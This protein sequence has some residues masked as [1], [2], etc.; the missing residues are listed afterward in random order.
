MYAH[1]MP[2]L[3]YEQEQ[4]LGNRLAQPQ[5]Y[6]DWR[7]ARDTLIL[8]NLGLVGALARKYQNDMYSYED[9]MQE[10][11]IGLIQAV[12][13]FQPCRG[14]RL[15]TYAQFW[16]KQSMIRAMVERGD[17]IRVPAPAHADR[18]RIRQAQQLLK[19]TLGRTATYEELAQAVGMPEH[20]VI[21]LCGMGHATISL[22]APIG[23]E[24]DTVVLD[25]I[26]APDGDP[27]QKATLDA[28]R[29]V[30]LQAIQTLTKPE[31]ELL[32]ARY[33]LNGEEPCTLEQ[34]S[35]KM[36]RSR[37]R[38]RELEKRSLLKLRR[39]A[40]LKAFA[41]GFPSNE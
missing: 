38:L 2:L 18:R 15:S 32:I 16:I 10:G 36:N 41:H 13:N 37:E 35:K 21:Q 24:Q 40:P 30:L 11:I 14:T 19:E 26:P 29:Q 3:K 7:S 4:E 9:L 6:A 22:D 25:Q 33:G 5:N 12:D 27:L 1:Q 23:E 34:L 31:Q 28:T 8:S 17:M 39:I 20:K